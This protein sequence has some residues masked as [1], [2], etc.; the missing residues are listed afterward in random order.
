MWWQHCWKHLKPPWTT[1]SLL[2]TQKTLTLCL[3][4]PMHTSQP[5]AQRIFWWRRQLPSERKAACTDQWTRS[6]QWTAAGRRKTIGGN[7]PANC[8]DCGTLLPPLWK[9]KGNVCCNSNPYLGWAMGGGM[10]W[11]GVVAKHRPSFTWFFTLT[12]Q[13]ENVQQ[14]NTAASDS[15]V[16]SIRSCPQQNPQCSRTCTPVPVTY[17]QTSSMLTHL[18]ACSSNIC[19]DFINA[20]APARLFQ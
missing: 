15:L 4:L 12:C 6:G 17:V 14:I 13:Q 10:G 3:R 19:T 20:H 8:W 1:K 11:G 2:S 16:P 7:A 5:P 9:Q 18:H